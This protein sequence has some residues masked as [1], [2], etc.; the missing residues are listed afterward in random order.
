MVYEGI[1]DGY[2]TLNAPNAKESEYD[3]SIAIV[4]WDDNFPKEN[5]NEEA[6]QN[7]AWITYNS[8]HPREYYYVSY[9]TDHD[10]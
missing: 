1:H 8:N 7:G 3:H 2:Y 10:P 5:F 6:S 9:D 4:G